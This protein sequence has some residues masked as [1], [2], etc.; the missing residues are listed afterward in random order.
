MERS[1]DSYE[2]SAEDIKDSHSRKVYGRVAL[3]G[4]EEESIQ[5]FREYTA[6]NNIPVPT[7]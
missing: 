3:D 1:I 7:W 2:P 5:I 4:S 6:K